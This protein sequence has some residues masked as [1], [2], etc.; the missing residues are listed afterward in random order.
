MGYH[1]GASRRPD[2]GADTRKT[3]MEGW[4]PGT[5]PLTNRLPAE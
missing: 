1:I 5:I 2:S 3:T 4:V